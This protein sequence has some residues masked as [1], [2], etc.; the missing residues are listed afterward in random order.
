LPPISVSIEFTASEQKRHQPTLTWTEF[1]ATEYKTA[2][3]HAIYT[4]WL[5]MQRLPGINL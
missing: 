5:D 4:A 2:V 3:F 1:T